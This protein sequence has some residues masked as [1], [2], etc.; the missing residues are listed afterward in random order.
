MDH[1]VI[2]RVWL[3]LV[4]GLWFLGYLFLHKSLLDGWTGWIGLALALAGL[5]MII[6]ARYTLGRSFSIAAKARELVTHGIYSRIRNPIYIGGVIFISG[7]C[8]IMR[9]PQLWLI[10]LLVIPLQLV[11]ARKEARVLESAFG[12]SYREYRKRTWL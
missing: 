11:R 4:L 1:G 2:L 6:I 12:E 10:L 8:L 3:P 7:I 9:M 5:T